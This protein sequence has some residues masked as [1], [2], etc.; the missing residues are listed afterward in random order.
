MIGVD[1]SAPIIYS[2]NGNLFKVRT[3]GVVL[4]DINWPK[5]SFVQ[6]TSAGVVGFPAW[7]MGAYI[8]DRN[9]AIIA[10]VGIT[11]NKFYCATRNGGNWSAVRSI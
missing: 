2:I 7:F 5:V 10:G 11:D 4:P 8:S 6:T 9:D 1:F 3:L